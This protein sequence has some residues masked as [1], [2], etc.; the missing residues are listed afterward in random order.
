ALPENEFDQ[1]VEKMK[2]PL[3][4]VPAD[5]EQGAE[6]FKNACISCHAINVDGK[7]FGPNLNG[8]ADRLTIAGYL[9]HTDENLRDWLADPE[10]VKPG[11]K[12]IIAP[13]SDEEIDHLVKY[14]NTLK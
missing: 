9:S 12:M 5:A 8:F 4:A 10:E 1:W 14:L 6:I 7:S 2:A 13:L 11:N 3:A